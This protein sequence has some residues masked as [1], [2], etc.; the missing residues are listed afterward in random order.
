MAAPPVVYLR[1]HKGEADKELATLYAVGEH[2]VIPR[3][4]TVEE[5]AC[6]PVQ[7]ALRCPYCKNVLH[8]PTTANPCGDV[9]CKACLEKLMDDENAACLV[10]D[11]KLEPGTVLPSKLAQKMVNSIE[12]HCENG[13]SYNCKEEQFTLSGWRMPNAT[14]GQRGGGGCE[15]VMTLGQF[16]DHLL[17]CPYVLVPCSNA[18]LGCP[19]IVE[20]R[21]Q[22]AH[23][24]GCQY[25]LDK[26]DCGQNIVR[27]LMEEHEA[28]CPVA[29]VPCPHTQFGCTG[30]FSAADMATHLETCPYEAVKMAL[31]KPVA[32]KALDDC[33]TL[34]MAKMKKM[35]LSRRPGEESD[36]EARK[37]ALAELETEALTMLQEKTRNVPR[38]IRDDV[39]EQLQATLKISGEA[40]GQAGSAPTEEDGGRAPEPPRGIKIPTF[41]LQQM[42]DATDNFSES[43]FLGK[44]AFGRVYKGMLQGTPVAV[45]RLQDGSNIED[46]QA[47]VNM[48]C[49][50]RHPN[51]VLLIG[52][53]V[54]AL[55]IVYE[56]LSGGS[57]DD[58]LKEP[59]K[60]NLTWVDRLRICSEMAAALLHM[61]RS[62]H[63]LHRDLKPANVMLDHNKTCKLADMG[64]AKLFGADAQAIMTCVKGTFGYIDPEWIQTGEFTT[65]SD[66]YALGFVMLQLLT[67][68][69]RIQAV[70]SALE[71][72]C[73]NYI[74]KRNLDR[75]VAVFMKKLDPLAGNWGEE[76][77][78]VALRLAIQCT[79]RL[80]GDRPDLATVLQ[81]EFARLAASAATAAR[82]TSGADPISRS[83]STS[84]NLP[85]PAVGLVRR[86]GSSGS[87]FNS[88]PGSRNG[89]ER[90]PQ[91]DSPGDEL[92]GGEALLTQPS[93]FKRIDSF[94]DKKPGA[95]TPPNQSNSAPSTTTNPALLMPSSLDISGAGGNTPPH[96]ASSSRS[97][98]S[99]GG[100]DYQSMSATPDSLP[101]FRSYVPRSGGNL[102]LPSEGTIMEGQVPEGLAD[103]IPQHHQRSSSVEQIAAPAS[104]FAHISDRAL[105][106]QGAAVA[107]G[108]SPGSGTMAERHYLP[109][110]A[111]APGGSSDEAAAA[112]V[113]NVDERARA[114]AYP[115]ASPQPHV[116][117]AY[118]G[119]QQQTSKRSSWERVLTL[120]KT[121][122]TPS[123]TAAAL[124]L[125][126]QSKVLQVF[127]HAL[128][129][130]SDPTLM[131]TMQKEAA[132][133]ERSV[134]EERTL[135]NSSFGSSETVGNIVRSISNRSDSSDGIDAPKVVVVPEYISPL[136]Q[137]LVWLLKGGSTAGAMKDLE[138][139][140]AAGN[141]YFKLK[142][143]PSS[144]HY[145]R[146]LLNSQ[147]VPVCGLR[148]KSPSE[149]CFISKG[150]TFSVSSYF[151]RVLPAN[152]GGAKVYLPG[153]D[154]KNADFEIRSEDKGQGSDVKYSILT[155][156][157]ETLADVFC[158]RSVGGAWGT[159]DSAYFSKQEV[160]VRACVDM[161]FVAALVSFMDKQV[162]AAAVSGGSTKP[163]P[164]TMRR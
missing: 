148:W 65:S 112:S 105:Y 135:A 29:A 17:A 51:T 58:H 50:I 72:E 64:L 80:G 60:F 94:K 24:E 160:T 8:E 39:M 23:V 163:R 27:A 132:L 92:P 130:R 84:G 40:L 98:A 26:C 155:S 70:H 122:P 97:T 91:D 54:D 134:R 128:H 95:A 103:S 81:P 13:L 158:V 152:N 48:L 136:D 108:H 5:L 86:I 109:Q 73:G 63:I 66:I 88:P 131:K 150:D 149:E 33:L 120:Q 62:L 7:A 123:A 31:Y 106:P 100:L 2:S 162:V 44:G 1:S 78:L 147:D 157:R 71:K 4:P 107:A 111:S 117:K 22:R 145:K 161:A 28:M 102:H 30:K 104:M 74:P 87:N 89:R 55:C 67:G 21:S 42:E 85:P 69:R 110:S 159:E 93:S 137:E 35:Q 38:E 115:S 82:A 16:K 25:Y 129:M 125:G 124:P 114:H 15:V 121:R 3:R 76:Q 101:V 118:T 56:F 12:V 53:S 47:E 113:A 46:F 11:E 143:R 90:D 9:Y 153:N 142:V 43:N 116:V 99:S 138:F 41:T 19:E 164:A 127:S 77:A 133:E 119:F 49:H 126:S 32:E 96:G 61:H 36:A 18:H 37:R 20:K 59:R 141:L 139:M 83:T 140:D 146:V 156:R 151:A 14:P 154:L 79:E 6:N 68:L 75:A 52:C 10:C 144:R 45:K 34:V 57:L